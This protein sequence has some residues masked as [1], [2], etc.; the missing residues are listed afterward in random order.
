MMTIILRTVL[1]YLVILL[2]FRIM[3]KREIGQ[4]S[5]VDF[6]ISLMIAE[7]A[8]IAIEN[9]RD[10]LAHHLVP[11]FLLVFIQMVL[12]YGALKSQAFRKVVDG[13][14]SVIIKNGKIDEGEMR[15][16]R[17]NFDDLL[18]QLRQKDICFMSDVDFAILEPSG[19]LSVIRKQEH[20]ATMMLP[21][22]MDGRIQHDHLEQLGRDES[23]LLAELKKRGFT[24]V[25]AISFCTLDRGDDLYIDLTD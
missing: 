9:F 6:V 23:W 20:P 22:I 7:L 1:V 24:D 5:V 21:F 13:S 15:R 8:A 19:Q 2:V 17:Y 4:L 10:P 18:L 3:G 25:A 11:L 14:P 16:Q 12:A